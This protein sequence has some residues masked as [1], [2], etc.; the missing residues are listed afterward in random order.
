MLKKLL[1]S[2]S[3]STVFYYTAAI[4][5][6]SLCIAI[7][8]FPQADIENIL[9]TA[10][11]SAVFL[12]L[13]NALNIGQKRLNEIVVLVV[14]AIFFADLCTCFILVIMNRYAYT[15]HK[16]L[17]CFALQ[18]VLV[19]LWAYICNRIFYTLNKP[20][21]VTVIFGGPDKGSYY[22]EKILKRPVNFEV[23]NVVSYTS[24]D[25]LDDIEMC[26][27]V[28][29]LGIPDGE[30]H[31]IIN[32]CVKNKKG[33]YIVPE[34]YEIVMNSSVKFTVDDVP[35]L[36]C[37]AL[38]LTK[39][40][41]VIK[42]A[43]D[44]LVAAAGIIATLPVMLVIGGLIKLYDGGPVIYRQQRITYKYRKFQLYKFRTMIPDAEKHSGAVLAAR[45]DERITPVGRVLRILRLDELPQLFNIMLGDMSVVGPRPEREVFIEKYINEIP[46]FEYRLNVK[47][48]LTG[49]GQIRGKY[50]TTAVD[51]LKYDLLYIQEYS[52]LQDIKIMF[53]TLGVL[54]VK[55]AAQGVGNEISS[56]QN[57][58]AEKA[59]YDNKVE[60]KI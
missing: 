55:D 16:V 22:I 43:F 2:I 54:F 24:A 1:Q 9:I 39:D 40:Q 45:N 56:Y 7:I 3:V 31:N 25:L 15:L 12:K 36:Y 60:I 8:S 50:N 23:I 6:I 42:R 46:G 51:K 35:I 28:F 14:L 26:D 19:V 30:K 29:L 10:L 37:K 59:V 34:I 21:K 4:I 53:Q 48:G 58:K 27:Y 38:E 47:A 17:M 13:Y 41:R 49:L 5:I 44:L 18:S 33:V 57:A 32:Y 11:F 20:L 52:L